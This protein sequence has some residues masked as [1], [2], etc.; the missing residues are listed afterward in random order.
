[1]TARVRFPSA[2]GAAL[3]LALASLNV[4]AAT[5]GGDAELIQR[6]QY[7][8]AA[9][10]CVAC[11]TAPGGKPMAGGLSLATPLGPSVSTN[12]TPSKTHGIGNYTLAQFSDALR[13]GVRADGQRL[14]PAM[15][16]TSY[17]LVTDGD[18]QALYVW[19]MHAVEPV[20]SNPPATSVPFP[21][22]IRLSM[23]AWNLLFLDDKPF[24]PDAGKTPEWNRGAYLTRGLAHCSACHTPRNMLM[25][26]QSSRELAGADVGAWNA[27]NITSDMNSGIGGWSEQELV[28]YMR[29]GSAAKGQVAGPMTEAIDN[30]LRHL[31]KEDLQAIAV[32]LKSVPAQHDATDS[33]PVYTWGAAG[34]ELNSIRGAAW[35]KDRNRMTGPQLYDAYCATCHQARGQGS[36]DGGLPSLFHNTA[37]GRSN[38]GNLVMVMLEGVQRQGEPAQVR[39][40]GFA[41]ELS[42][43]QIATLGSYL[44]QHYGNPKAQVSAERVQQL[45]AGGSSSTNLVMLA[46]VGMALAL[47]VIIALIV[48]FAR[49][50]RNG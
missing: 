33:K 37:T 28:D 36:F 4:C 20:E 7:L 32:Y 10:D 26:E 49:R 34:D 46:R 11:H 13:R 35:P 16:Y 15:P 12:I 41:H 5:A 24:V 1:M 47:V 8:A 45:R 21:F 22:N 14:Y 27:P 44:T 43:Q 38:P 6:G 40:P 48:M 9:G 31:T 39:M 3:A 23:A 17:A 50:K 42:D 25:A 29:L 2:L 19:F 18:V 30:S